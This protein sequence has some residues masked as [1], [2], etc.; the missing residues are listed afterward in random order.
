[1]TAGVDY[2]HKI[3][4][5]QF[6]AQVWTL[7]RQGE[8]WWLT[9]EEDERLGEL[10]SEFEMTDEVEDLIA[11]SYPWDRYEELKEVGSCDWMNATKI[12]LDCGIKNPVKSQVRRAGE[13]L[14]KLTGQD[15]PARIG[16]SRDKCYLMPSKASFYS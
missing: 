14:R 1:P 13:V 12:L 8:I 4:I 5:Q 16:K 9:P 7:Y 10:N 11:S 15:K 2:G 6:W 3:D